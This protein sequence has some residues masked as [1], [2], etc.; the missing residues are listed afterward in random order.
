MKHAARTTSHFGFPPLVPLMS[1]HNNS[2]ARFTR[3]QRRN[4][5]NVWSHCACSLFFMNE[6]SPCADCPWRRG[7]FQL[8]V[9]G[10]VGGTWVPNHDRCVYVRDDVVCFNWMS[11]GKC[12]VG[13]LP[14]PIE[15][16]TSREN[17]SCQRLNSIGPFFERP[18]WT[19][20]FV[21][22]AIFGRRFHR[23]PTSLFDQNQIEVC[24]SGRSVC[25]KTCLC[26]NI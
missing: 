1:A 6:E 18:I 10:Q 21:F 13:F 8:D 5:G 22:S 15:A 11:W 14:T 17:G 26:H 3:N 19:L 24:K 2:H 4:S 23:N 16:Y 7:M 9:L 12:A 20:I 25:I